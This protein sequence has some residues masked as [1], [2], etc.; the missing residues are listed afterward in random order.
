MKNKFIAAAAAGFLSLA[1][2]TALANMETN[3]NSQPTPESNGCS[4]HSCGAKNG[5]SGSDGESEDS[6]ASEKT[7]EDDCMVKCYGVAMAGKNDCSSKN[8]SH[9]CAGQAKENCSDNEWVAVKAS[10]CK[11]AKCDTTE[12]NQDVS[13][14]GTYDSCMQK[15]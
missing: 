4:S 11:A 3:P 10:E 8:G 5:G 2:N 1:S 15:D 6:E 7:S 13:K 14:A 12:N 9:G